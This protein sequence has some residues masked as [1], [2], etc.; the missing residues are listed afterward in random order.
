MGSILLNVVTD[1]F[2]SSVEAI[3]S[4]SAGR[5]G[6]P[7]GRLAA[8]AWQAGRITSAVSATGDH[9]APKAIPSPDSDGT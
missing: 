3:V 2:T 6:F 9:A 8:W 1:G 7:Q 4:Q 5:V